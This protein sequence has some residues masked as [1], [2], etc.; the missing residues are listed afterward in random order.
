MS[1]YKF[2]NNDSG[3]VEDVETIR[4]FKED[5]NK[6]LIN[7]S[8][9]AT[10]EHLLEEVVVDSQI[11]LREGDIISSKLQSLDGSI[12]T[13]NNLDIAVAKH[14]IYSGCFAI[15]SE[16]KVVGNIFENPDLL[17]ASMLNKVKN[18]FGYLDHLSL[19]IKELEKSSNEEYE[20]DAKAFLGI[21]KN[22]KNTFR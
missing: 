22:K 14:E 21:S 9:G 6:I 18:R 1:V 20:K 12:E 11:V 8:F 19:K 2:F 16:I 7:E 13:E 10:K 4:Y 15:P 17:N 5:K 3:K